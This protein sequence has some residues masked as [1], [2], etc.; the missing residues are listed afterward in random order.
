MHFSVVVVTDGGSEEE[1][2]GALAPYDETLEAD[3]WRSYSELDWVRQIQ[4]DVDDATL[5]AVIGERWPDMV[6]GL[7]D[8]GL[9]LVTTW[10]PQG[11]WD[12]WQIGG[13]WQASLVR[14]DGAMVDTGPVGRIDW[15]ATDAVTRWPFVPYAVVD[16]GWYLPGDAGDDT[17]A[18]AW[19]RSW[20][21]GLS[22][23]RWVTVV[24][25]HQ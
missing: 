9:Y 17:E 23:S 1:V 18:H 20:V 16:D 2:A 15:V 21:D 8:T 5:L 7:D 11:Q 4:G 25:C 22:P 3:P 10:N 6:C 12:W 14:D 24:D 13:R 19:F